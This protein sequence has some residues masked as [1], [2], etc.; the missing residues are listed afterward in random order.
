MDLIG[1]VGAVPSPLAISPGFESP[2]TPPTPGSASSEGGYLLV[3]GEGRGEKSKTLP[4]SR[5]PRGMPT[6]ALSLG[7]SIREELY[8]IQD[9]LIPFDQSIFNDDPYSP[10]EEPLSPTS[11]D[12]PREWKTPGLDILS[13]S[14]DSA[15]GAWGG[16]LTLRPSRKKKAN[17]SRNRKTLMP[18][19]S[20]S[21]DITPPSPVG[22]PSAFGGQFTRRGKWERRGEGE[23]K[24]GD[25]KPW[26]RTTAIRRKK[27]KSSVPEGP[28]IPEMSFAFQ[29]CQFP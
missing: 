3:N 27:H 11:E 24:G 12:I 23:G 4:A 2:S 5:R 10:E 21:I 14:V 22:S 7:T 20:K 26:K 29:V 9:S 15:A 1:N 18:T 17:H 6:K 19:S 8:N 13:R 25:K 16:F 28:P